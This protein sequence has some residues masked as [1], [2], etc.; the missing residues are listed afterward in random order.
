MKKFLWADHFLQDLRYGFRIL[1]KTPGFTL[2]AVVSLG[3]GIMATTAMYSVIHGVVLNPFPYRD[4]DTLMSVKVWDPG[5]RGWRTYY[6]TDQFLEIEARNSIFEGVIASTISDVLWTGDGKPRRL[7][8]NHVTTNTFQILGVLRCWG[9]QSRGTMAL[10]TLLPCAC[11]ATVSGSAS[12]AA[13]RTCWA[14]SFD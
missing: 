6:S 3:L 5:G 11:L 13:I 8:G 14:A 4:V 10:R 2:L 9:A 12:S 1:A 7:R